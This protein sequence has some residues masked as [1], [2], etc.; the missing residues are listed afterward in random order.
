MFDFT[1]VYVPPNCFQS[2]VFQSLTCYIDDYKYHWL[3]DKIP[4]LEK[5]KQ[6]INRPLDHIHGC[7]S[8]DFENGDLIL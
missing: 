2:I 3:K 6:K 5:K 1:L 8:C 7:E 4:T